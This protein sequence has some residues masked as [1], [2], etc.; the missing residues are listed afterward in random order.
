MTEILGAMRAY[1]TDT[2]PERD[3][4][5]LCRTWVA[6]TLGF[7]QLMDPRSHASYRHSPLAE[8]L[9]DHWPPAHR[10]DNQRWFRS[11][12][13][14]CSVQDLLRLGWAK[15]EATSTES[16][17]QRWAEEVLLLLALTPEQIEAEIALWG[18]QEHA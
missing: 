3:I 14:N 4:P 6:G 2:L 11:P 1:V 17:Y 5:A 7:E 9:F 18:M 15:A 12:F 8:R 13:D 16:F 10:N